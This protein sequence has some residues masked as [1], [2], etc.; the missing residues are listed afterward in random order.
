MGHRII[1]TK[2]ILRDI[3]FIF[4]YDTGTVMIFKGHDLI[5]LKHMCLGYKWK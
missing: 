1:N 4:F 5:F 3:F 2:N